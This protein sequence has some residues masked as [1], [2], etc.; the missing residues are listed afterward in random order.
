MSNKYI[1]IKKKKIK[2][3]RKGK[4]ERGGRTKEKKRAGEF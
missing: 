3:N 1:Q 4:I 2:K